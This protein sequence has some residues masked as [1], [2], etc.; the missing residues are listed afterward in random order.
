MIKKTILI[1]GVTSGIGRSLVKALNTKENNLIITGRSDEKMTLLL[2]ELE[3][4]NS[5]YH[6]TFDL[7][8]ETAVKQFVNE[9][10]NHFGTIDILINNA[11]ANTSRS[12]TGELETEKLQELLNINCIAPFTL[13]R[14]VYRQSMK[15]QGAGQIINVMS[16]VCH[17]SNEGIGAY[18]ASKAAYDALTKVFRKEVRE[19]G[20]KINNIYPGGVDTPFRDSERP[21]YLKP[22][23]VVNAIISMMG[24]D[25]ISSVDELVIRPMIEKNYT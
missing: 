25:D 18:T 11:G 24:Y 2:S 13:M 7:T 10:I 22:E 6:K 8:D 19:E 14:E 16:T 23:S 4:I 9:G 15:E 17:F 21:L 12:K 5:I 20:I 1:T 3:D